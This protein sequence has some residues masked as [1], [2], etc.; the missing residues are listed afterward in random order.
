LIEFA[1]YEYNRVLYSSHTKMKRILIAVTLLVVIGTSANAQATTPIKKFEGMWSDPPATI[2]GMFCASR[3]TDVGIER[4]NALI[5]D[6]A[7]DSRPVD[8]LESEAGNYQ[9]EKYIRP[10]L[11]DAA[12]KDYPLDPAEDPSFLR[13]EPYGFAR[14]FVSRH[15]L[16][17]KQIGKDR[18]DFH[19][20][21]W[22]AHRTVYLDGRKPQANQG[23]S[24]LGFSVGHWEGE[25]LVIETSGIRADIAPW[26]AKHSEQLHVVE[27]Y[28]RS[29]DGKTLTVAATMEDPWGLREPLVLKHMWG[30]RPD[31]KIAAYDQCE[32]PKEF[33]R[34]TGR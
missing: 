2:L 7:N 6:P 27:R 10:R 23:S 8:R 29:A 20:G 26:G 34:G 22:D 33:K 25:A 16:E 28:T 12:S 1:N 24:L 14:Q 13:C 15:Q 4:L 21:E 11:S 32:I 30:W 17:I 3:C 19:Y 9:M 31:Q 18:L 5:D